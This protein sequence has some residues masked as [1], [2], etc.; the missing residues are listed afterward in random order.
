VTEAVPNVVEPGWSARTT[1]TAP[2]GRFFRLVWWSDT[3]VGFEHRC[4]RGPRGVIVCAPLLAIG[5][6]H[7]VTGVTRPT[8][9]AS[10]LCDDCGL[11][12]FITD[13]VWSDA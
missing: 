8:V 5:A 13:G 7:H 4:D 1:I 2:G 10:V 9:R 12:G 6:G 11:H 3:K